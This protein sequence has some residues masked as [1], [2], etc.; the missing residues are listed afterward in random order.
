MI[1]IREKM[2]TIV[3]TTLAILITLVFVSPFVW[4]ISSSLRPYASLYSTEFKIIPDDATLDSFRWAL[5]ES[6]FFYW[7]KNSLIVYIISLVVS[8]SITIPAGYTFSRFSFF[9]KNT[10]LNSYFVLT[11][12]MSGMG[13][14][15]LI[16]LYT[17]LVRIRLTNSL[18]T[19]GLIYAA[20]VVPFI[21][22][23]LKTYFD[24]IPRDFDEAAILDGA[25]FSQIWRYVIL[26]I[27]K[28]GI[29]TAIIFISIIIWSEWIIGGILL[30]AD[31]FTLAV[32]LVTLQSSWETPWNHFA[33]MA[34]MYAI[35]ICII[36]MLARR[37]LT[38]GLTMGGLKG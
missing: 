6:K 30:S 37:Y 29:Y 20:S 4:I 13:I 27:S 28:P 14:I 35:P 11:Q 7:F 18:V 22:W 23:Y 15:A 17:I 24:S 5:F 26:P 2:L 12:F 3:L 33:A 34:L 8:L 38:A 25:S 36:F 16:P 19:L 10:L 31:K 1:R 21:T 9:G 32:G